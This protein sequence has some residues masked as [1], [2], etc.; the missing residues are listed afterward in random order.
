MLS[1]LFRRGSSASTKLA[2]IERVQG[3]IEF[4]PDGRVLAASDTLLAVVGFSRREL[5]GQH[6][7]RLCDPAYAQ[8]AEYAALWARLR[9]GEHDQGVYP[10]RAKDGREIWLQASYNP[11]TRFGRVTRIVKFATDVTAQTREAAA[12]ASRMAALDATQ[13]MV[14][15]DLDGTIRR[16]NAN[17][18]AAMGYT[19][20]EI[21][22][23][24]HRLFCDPALAASAE[25][26]A[27]WQRL[28]AGEA[29]TGT[30]RR[31]ARGGR[32]IWIEGSY[33][34]LLDAHGRPTGVVKACTDVT[35]QVVSRQ[36][37][38]A[39][40]VDA[41][42]VLDAMAHGDLT[43]RT[44]G[45]YS[46]GLQRLAANLD[47]ASET[48]A[49]TL[50]Q[51]DRTATAVASAVGQLSEGS[52]DLASRTQ[53]QVAALEET[54]A[55][56]EE[57]T[58]SVTRNVEHVQAADALGRDTRAAAERSGL[59]MRDAL[60]AMTQIAESGRRIGDITRV[61][62]DIS[63]QTNI[64][65]L[66][67]AVEAAR[68]GDHGRGFAVVADEVRSL[69][70]RS[71]SAARE[72]SG[73]IDEALARVQDGNR[74]VGE[75]ATTLDEIVRA[76]QRVSDLVAQVRTAS[77]E[78]AA[79]ISQVNASLGAV[80]ANNQQNAA[81]G[82]QLSSA[83]EALEVEAGRLRAQVGSFT[84]SAYRRQPDGR[85]PATARAVTPAEPRTR[86]VRPAAMAGVAR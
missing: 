4:S 53:T 57:L 34:P 28:S 83:S 61:I 78:Q 22:G 43:H 51:V 7:R 20:D 11:V 39:L 69:A 81:L 71:A 64:L 18:L 14:E 21:V 3:W 13:A 16:A 82:V 44:E 9:R 17:F 40:V 12:T 65:A 74:L 33:N 37:V 56:V 15:F 27:F 70:L 29:F 72:I 59:V 8:T 80:D 32:E 67:A 19:L 48:L 31:L 58:A 62:D 66:N 85:G 5:V 55:A 10:R 73:H 24:H 42:R 86:P 30:Y 26:A 54:A 46:G 38:E 25:Y 23:R 75:T 47:Q 35:A 49:N 77:E 79:G 1:A 76:V 84:L 41:G 36:Q 52:R 45:R 68:A 60:G 63:F 6:H 2:A 50:K